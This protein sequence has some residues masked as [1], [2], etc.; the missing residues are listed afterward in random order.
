MIHI[1]YLVT[2]EQGPQHDKAGAQVSEPPAEPENAHAEVG[3]ADH[4][5]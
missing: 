5:G 2:V 4:D 1:L 3:E